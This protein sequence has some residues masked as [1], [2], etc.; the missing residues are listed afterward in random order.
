MNAGE[1]EEWNESGINK[2]ASR[3]GRRA[4]ARA[5]VH[6][7]ASRLRQRCVD[8]SVLPSNKFSV[9]AYSRHIRISFPRFVRRPIASREYD[10]EYGCALLH[11]QL[12][13]YTAVL[14]TSY[15][16]LFFSRSPAPCHEVRVVARV[17]S[18]NVAPI[19]FFLLPRVQFTLTVYFTLTIDFYGL[20]MLYSIF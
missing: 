5:G 13:L 14:E 19:S 17:D 2:L 10:Q 20:K 18:D 6:G 11:G 4:G 8:V 15:C 16:S 12:I 9:S 3:R 1:R 7:S